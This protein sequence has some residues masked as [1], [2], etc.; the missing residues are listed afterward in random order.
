MSERR[1]RNK[2]ASR[3]ERRVTSKARIEDKRETL[4]SNKV[5]LENI[6]RRVF[7]VGSMVKTNRWIGS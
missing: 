7:S 2:F 1:E 4:K 6:I 3:A 5:K